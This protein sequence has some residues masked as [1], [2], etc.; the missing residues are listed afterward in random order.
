MLLTP[1]LQIELVAINNGPKLVGETVTFTATVI[2][3]NASGLTFLWNFD[4]GQTAQGKVVQHRYKRNGTFTAV[5]IATNSTSSTRAET[6]VVISSPLSP[7]PGEVPIEGLRA[8]S[9]APTVAGKP[10]TFIAAVI[11]G[12]NIS[13]QWDFGDGQVIENAKSSISYT[14]AV[15]GDYLVTV[16]AINSVNSATSPIL[17]VISEAPPH[18]I[19]LLIPE[20]TTINTPTVFTATLESGTNLLF[21]WVFSD[22]TI[23]TIPKVDPLQTTSTYTHTFDHAKSYTISVYVRNSSGEIS[24]SK[25]ILV[26]PVVPVLFADRIDN[27]KASIV[28]TVLPQLTVSGRWRTFTTAD[29][30]LSSNIQALAYR[31][32]PLDFP[33]CDRQGST[34]PVIPGLWVGTD[35]GLTYLNGRDHAKF[36]DSRPNTNVDTRSL[37]FADGKLWIATAGGLTWLDDKGTPQDSTDDEWGPTYLSNQ[38]ILALTQSDRQI[39]AGTATGLVR[40]NPISMQTGPLLTTGPV[41]AITRCAAA[42]GDACDVIFDHHLWFAADGKIYRLDITKDA[43]TPV[44]VTELPLTT[45]FPLTITS[46]I[47][48]TEGIWIASNY[49][50]AFWNGKTWNSA[51]FHDA[52]NHPPLRNIRAIDID[53]QNRIWLAT[54][55]DAMYWDTQHQTWRHYLRPRNQIASNNIQA[56]LLDPHGATWLGTTAG[57]SGVNNAWT[58]LNQAATYNDSNGIAFNNLTALS[59]DNQKRTWLAT[60]EPISK[61]SNL[62]ML[63]PDL[64]LMTA[65]ITITN[66]L[67]HN[68]VNKIVFDNKGRAWLPTWDLPSQQGVIAIVEPDLTMHVPFTTSLLSEWVSALIFDNQDRTWVGTSGG[69]TVI[70]PDLTIRAAFTTSNRLINNDVQ[71]LVLDTDNRVWVGTSG[72]VTVIDSDLTVRTIFTTGNGLIN[73][74]VQTLAL[75]TDN[76]VWVGTSGGLT[77][78]DPDLTVRTTFTTG[79]GLINNNVQAISFDDQDR[80]WVGTF[81][82]VTVIAP[83][84]TMYNTIVTTDVLTTTFIQAVT[85]D[86]Q[87]RAWL[88]TVNGMSIFAPNTATPSWLKAN[89]G[90]DCVKSCRLLDSRQLTLTISGGSLFFPATAL[91]YRLTLTNTLDQRPVFRQTYPI[92]TD[93]QSEILFLTIDQDRSPVYTPHQLTIEVFDHNLGAYNL[94]PLIFDVQASP[95]LNL[96]VVDQFAWANRSA[97]RPISPLAT[98]VPPLSPLSPLERVSLPTP[99]SIQERLTFAAD[100]SFSVQWYATDPDFDPGD[101]ITFTYVWD[102]SDRVQNSLLLTL[103]QGATYTTLIHTPK[104]DRGAANERLNLA[105]NI[106]D[107]D[108]NSSP[109]QLIRMTIIAPLNYQRLLAPYAGTLAGVSLMLFFGLVM[110]AR[111]SGLPVALLARQG[112]HGWLEVGLSY[113]RY[114]ERWAMLT[115]LEQLFL[116]LTPTVGATPAAL[117]TALKR[118]HTPVSETRFNAALDTLARGQFL[119]QN[120]GLVRPLELRCH[121][122]LQTHTGDITLSQIAEQVRTK[123]PLFATARHFFTAAGFDMQP[124]A[125]P[126]AFLCVPTASI[127]QRQLT[128]PVY[129]RLFPD[130]E[131]GQAAVANLGAAARQAINQ[132]PATNPMLIFALVDHTPSDSGW[133]AI[134]ALRAEGI[135]VVPV[136][137]GLMQQARIEQQEQR[138]LQLHI[139]RFIGRERDLFNVRDPVADRLNFFGRE[140]RSHD[141]L[142]ALIDGRPQALLGLRKMGKSSL[143]QVMRERAPFA[144]AHIDLQAGQEPLGLYTR[145]L[146]E[147]QQSLRVRQPTLAWTP[148]P[149]TGDPTTAFT[150]AARALLQTLEQAGLEARLGLFIDEFDLLMPRQGQLQDPVLLTRYLTVTQALRGLVQETGRLALLVAGVDARFNRVSRWGEAQ[151]PFYQ[152]FQETYLEPLSAADCQQMVRNIGRQMGLVFDDAAAV[153]VARLSGGHPFLARQLCSTALTLRQGDD[154]LLSLDLVERAAALFVRQPS[155]AANLDEQGLWGE[156]TNPALWPPAQIVEN[157]TLLQTLAHAEEKAEPDLLATGADPAA[158]TQ[159]LYE[160]TQRAVLRRLLPERLRIHLELFSAWIRAYRRSEQP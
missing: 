160:L 123:H 27:R 140:Q 39:W 121:C 41:T 55:A 104:L 62:S 18:G 142:E 130:E 2:S 115:P 17:V 89:V 96:L 45:T 36:V 53:S 57:L 116:L 153:A 72:G 86:N 158:R 113:T 78:I 67:S 4:D 13:Y 83:D 134:G 31:E 135:Q 70:N 37:L 56:L 25:P 32:D 38:P 95:R 71:T 54:N 79:N 35:R 47:R 77:V 107:K 63:R 82:G 99:A 133:I 44:P 43:P 151:N 98:A 124:V 80:V 102:I 69:L 66:G 106:T 84:L 33:F 12:T 3:G 93:N 21:E 111:N 34:C 48:S 105:L 94:P 129:A 136:D 46:I 100:T 19:Q 120:G 112:P 29:G 11:T 92:R 157:Q 155:T 15:P 60:W 128:G 159:S 42:L 14:Y 74:D 97:S 152:F 50:I 65:T 156:V 150:A 51:P 127:W 68:F 146:Q 110:L 22:G 73:N 5:V 20:I 23:F 64:T 52:M 143:L 141:L 49:G 7:I 85:F 103:T 114:R 88:N 119:T 75:D 125:D 91:D 122:V 108:G 147:W 10:T 6:V 149:L 132:P 26:R 118:L 59:I 144:V 137:D 126:L 8:T 139:R 16:T 154:A 61:R 148:P 87:G 28:A 109:T 138:A 145:I 24:A 30:L 1:A 90:L 131:L 9:D 76:R 58:L 81:D 117:L 40:I 101:I